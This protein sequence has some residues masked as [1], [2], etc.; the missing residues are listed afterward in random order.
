MK[1]SL[2]ELHLIM[3]QTAT[4]DMVKTITDKYKSKVPPNLKME[5]TN[6]EERSEKGDYQVDRN[7]IRLKIRHKNLQ[8]FIE[9]VLHE[10]H[11]AMDAKRYNGRWGKGPDGYEMAYEVEMSYQEGLG[12]DRYDDNKY[13]IAAEKWCKQE[14]RRK[15]KNFKF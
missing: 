7:T 11:H 6:Y 4:L 2:M 5:F 10:I 15:W 1:H 12:K 3:E 13:E 8:D 9:T 14:Y